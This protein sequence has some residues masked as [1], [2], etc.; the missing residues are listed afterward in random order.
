MCALPLSD[1]NDAIAYIS[2]TAPDCHRRHAKI[3]PSMPP[4]LSIILLLIATAFVVLGSAFATNWHSWADRASAW[5]KRTFGRLGRG[6]T[7]QR[8]AGTT[9]VVGG[10]AIYIIWAASLSSG[11][12]GR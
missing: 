10:I 11:P 1:S 2:S 12:A 9:L 4:P 6:P 8:A 3:S 7:Y 5:N